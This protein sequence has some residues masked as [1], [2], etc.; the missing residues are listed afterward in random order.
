MNILSKFNIFLLTFLS[1]NFSPNLI[2]A[3]DASGGP[4]SLDMIFSPVGVF[5][6]LSLSLHM[7]L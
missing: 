6:Y 2:Q 7:A 3:A 1:F 4:T 5:V